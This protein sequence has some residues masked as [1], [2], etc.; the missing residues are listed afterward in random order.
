MGMLLDILTAIANL[1]A[2]ELSHGAVGS[3]G[4]LDSHALQNT[5]LGVHGGRGKLLGIHLSQTLVALNGVALAL[6]GDLAALCLSF[7]IAIVGVEAKT[8]DGIGQD[9]VFGL[10]AIGI[11]IVNLVAHLDAKDRRAR[12]VDIAGIDQ[13]DAC[14]CK[15]T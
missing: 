14:T 6:L 7:F 1:G 8:A 12:H 13:M 2:H 5:G 11:D 3:D 9:L 10:P 15:R 4:I